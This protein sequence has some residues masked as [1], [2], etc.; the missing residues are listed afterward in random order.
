MFPYVMLR[1]GCW[2]RT[3]WSDLLSYLY[4][5]RSYSTIVERERKRYKENGKYHEYKLPR[6]R[7]W[8]F[9][10]DDKNCIGFGT[11]VEAFGISR[12]FQGLGYGWQMSAN[13]LWEEIQ[14]Y[15][16][17]H[18]STHRRA[19]RCEKNYGSV[20]GSSLRQRAS[21]TTFF[22]DLLADVT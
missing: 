15:H 6:P 7:G 19:T 12:Y 20:T 4:R 10:C 2:A 1:D 14:Q 8:F 3:T 11:V 5:L 21:Y 13:F 16:S 17:R 22:H 9:R 18:H